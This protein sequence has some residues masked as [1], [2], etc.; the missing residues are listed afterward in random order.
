MKVVQR[1][2]RHTRLATTADLYTHV[3]ERLERD[4]ADRMD[5]ILETAP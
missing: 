3:S 2:L 5:T 1:V 4:T